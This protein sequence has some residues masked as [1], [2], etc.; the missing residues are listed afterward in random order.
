MFINTI[1]FNQSIR[2]VSI[3]DR[4]ID[5]QTWSFTKYVGLTMNGNIT[6][7][8]VNFIDGR[9]KGYPKYKKGTGNDN[10][11]YFRMVRG[12]VDYGKN[13][14][15]DNGDGTVSDFATGLMWQ[16]ADDGTGRDWQEA[17]SYA[18]N[19]ELAKYSDWRLPNAKELQS[20]VDYIRSPQTTSSPA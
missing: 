2:G 3:G 19:L 4:E 11:M 7:L 13:D 1:Y 8:G 18:E 9:I 14:F 16:K 10:T 6:I 5:A 20:I 17:L 12:N 15:V